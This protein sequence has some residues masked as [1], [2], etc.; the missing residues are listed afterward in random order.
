MHQGDGDGKSH[1]GGLS[2]VGAVVSTH[3]GL[4]GRLRQHPGWFWE[5]IKVL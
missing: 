5:V 3:S 2:L 1:P 4:S